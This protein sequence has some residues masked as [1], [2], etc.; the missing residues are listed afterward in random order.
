MVKVYL[1]CCGKDLSRDFCDAEEGARGLIR[2]PNCGCLYEWEVIDANP[3]GWDRRLVAVVRLV[4]ACPSHSSK[5]ET[6][7]K[8]Y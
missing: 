6:E 4:Q 7:T 2:C 1:S 5:N 8:V 3:T